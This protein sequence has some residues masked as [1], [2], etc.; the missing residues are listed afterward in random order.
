MAVRGLGSP[1]GESGEQRL[2]PPWGV[3]PWQAGEAAP[4]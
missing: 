2:F 1:S 3:A 4:C